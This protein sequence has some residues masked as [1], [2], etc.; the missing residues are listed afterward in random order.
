MAVQSKNAIK[1]APTISNATIATGIINNLVANQPAPKHIPNNPQLAHVRKYISILRKFSIAYKSIILAYDEATQT[2]KSIHPPEWQRTTIATST[3]DNCKNALIQITGIN[4]NIIVI[5][6]DGRNHHNNKKINELCKKYCKFIN[7]TR[8]GYHFFFRF[9]EE[10]AKCQS[11]KYLNDPENSGLDI[12][13]TNGCVYY[14]S[15]K[16]GTELIKYENLICED[17]VPMPTELIKELKTLFNKTNT[18]VAKQRITKAF[19][20][21]I[22]NTTDAFPSTTIIDITTLDK[23]ISCFPS[24]YFENYPKWIEIC[25]L[26][27]QSNH[28]DQA[29]QLFYK[30]SKSV[31]KYTNVSEEECRAKWDS[32]KYEPNFVFQ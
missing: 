16:I 6:T 25:F 2:K 13:S 18:P 4:S 5:D 20:N 9:T 28:T 15:Y 14:G 10:F 11:I 3:F 23:L 21:V 1:P 32:I 22:A 19:P 7:E 31:S 8:K 30:Y 24:T 29:F 12:K 27:K 26:I 17:I